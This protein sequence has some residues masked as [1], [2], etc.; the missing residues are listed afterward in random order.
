[1]GLPTFE[2]AQVM[3][4]GLQ[5]FLRKCADTAVQV[6]P[7]LYVFPVGHV[8]LSQLLSLSALLLPKGPFPERERPFFKINLDVFTIAPRIFV[9]GGGAPCRG[10][11][12]GKVPSHHLLSN[13]QLARRCA[14]W[15]MRQGNGVLESAT[16]FE[17]DAFPL[18]LEFS[19][20]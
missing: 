14:S 11:H 17:R 9:G 15:M 12:D 19:P 7:G 20:E 18:S 16:Y 4:K 13:P 10:I 5:V 6:F 8:H 2:L 1:M 3:D